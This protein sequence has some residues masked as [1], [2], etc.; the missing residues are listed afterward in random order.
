MEDQG[1]VSHEYDDLAGSNVDGQGHTEEVIYN[2]KIQESRPLQN[3]WCIWYVSRKLKDHSIP[4]EERLKKIGEFNSIEAFVN[5]YAHMKS[6]NDIERNID[7]SIFKKGYQP[8]WESCPNSAFLFC[9]YKKNEEVNDLNN[10]WEKLQ[11]SLVGEQFDEPTIL[12][13]TL[14][15][16]GRET[17]IELWFTY[18]KDEKLKEDLHTKFMEL[19]NFPNYSSIFFKDNSLSIQDKSTLKNIEN[20]KLSSRKNTYY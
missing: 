10:K 13:A 16:R 1:K 7:I 4:Y 20:L 2:H 5:Y 19:L 12:G 15:I 11:F 6:A 14:S 17:I 18:N 3:C 9:R 8:L